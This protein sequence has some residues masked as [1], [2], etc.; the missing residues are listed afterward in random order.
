M[1][2]PSR[3]QI[4]EPMECDTEGADL[5]DL[6]LARLLVYLDESNFKNLPLDIKISLK[7][8]VGVFVSQYVKR[9]RAVGTLDAFLKV[10]VKWLDAIVWFDEKS[11]FYFANEYNDDSEFDEEKSDQ[12]EINQEVEEIGN[13]YPDFEEPISVKS[14]N[15]IKRQ[16]TEKF[17]ELSDEFDDGDEYEV[18]RPSKTK[19]GRQV[20]LTK[21]LNIGQV[22]RRSKQNLTQLTPDAMKGTKDIENFSIDELLYVAE[23]SCIQNK[24]PDTRKAIKHSLSV[25]KNPKKAKENR[26]IL[27]E[28]VITYTPAEAVLLTVEND[29]LSRVYKEIRLSAKSRYADIYPTYAEVTKGKFACYPGGIAYNHGVTEVPLQNLL[30]H[31]AE[32][33]LQN[34]KGILSKMQP[35]TRDRYKVILSLKWGY[36]GSSGSSDLRRQDSNLPDVFC[37]SLVP[38]SMKHTDDVFWRN[39]VPTSVRFCRAISL[40]PGKETPEL[41]YEAQM[42]VESQIRELQPYSTELQMGTVKKLKPIH[43]KIKRKMEK[44][45]M[46]GFSKGKS[47]NLSQKSNEVEPPSIIAVDVFYHVQYTE[48][49]PSIASPITGSNVSL[50]CH[51]CAKP[52]PFDQASLN[53]AALL[54]TRTVNPD[55]F[56][57]IIS[58]LH[59]WVSCFE[60]L[61]HLACFLPQESWMT[62]AD[63]NLRV[64]QRKIEIQGAFRKQMGLV[65]DKPRFGCSVSVSDSNT[66][67]KA[68]Q[69]EEEFSRICGLNQDLIHK[70]NVILETISCDYEINGEEYG[71]YCLTTAELLTDLYPWFHI[72]LVVHKILYHGA[73]MVSEFILPIG[74]MSEETQN[75]RHRVY[76]PTFLKQGKNER[77]D[78]GMIEEMQHLMIT[79]DPILSEKSLTLRKAKQNWRALGE[80]PSLLKNVSAY[81]HDDW[82]AEDADAVDLGENDDYEIIDYRINSSDPQ[83]CVT[84]DPG[85]ALLHYTAPHAHSNQSAFYVPNS[86]VRPSPSHPNVMKMALDSMLRF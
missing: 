6:V 3:R 56:K 71:Q 80:V 41:A 38:V 64:S 14:N 65:I 77:K 57:N 11:K 30:N 69:S 53:A 29:L 44:E 23:R 21:R 34:Q 78:R 40:Q 2:V 19:R 50:E 54:P 51:M 25:A 36:D 16:K 37:T 74:M 62:G 61:I 10:E 32:R 60:C 59:A 31:T 55:S 46:E 27:E 66:A 81:V 68:F 43:W 75:S 24:R 5:K 22:P 26:N 63:I 13:L 85:T 76:K 20:K 84:D 7:K 12:D 58:P 39:P 70:F 28:D 45:A 72:P 86:N 9:F 1:V 67:K 15:P 47:C 18:I 4:L 48:V 35:N 33:I 73:Q 17:Y 79:S 8:S 52:S 83:I 49:E 42:R 82:L